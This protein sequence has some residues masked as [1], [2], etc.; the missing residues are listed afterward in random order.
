MIKLFLLSKLLN[1]LIQITEPETL[2]YVANTLQEG[3]SAWVVGKLSDSY[4]NEVLS[5]IGL[6]VSGKSMAEYRKRF[7]ELGL[8]IEHLE[9]KREMTFF[10]GVNE[11]R[12]WI[13]GQVGSELLTERYLAAMQEKGWIDAGDGRIGFP[14][15]QLLAQLQLKTLQ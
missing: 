11:L 2:E 9:I 7:E 5:S 13:K 6:P 14:T 3:E 4:E 1:S 12:T 10:N 8:E 15:K